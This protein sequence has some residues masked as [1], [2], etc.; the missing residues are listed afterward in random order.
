MKF[1]VIVAKIIVDMK[2]RYVLDDEALL[3][4]VVLGELGRPRRCWVLLVVEA[5]DIMVNNSHGQKLM[6]TYDREINIYEHR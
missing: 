1:V 4:L 2:R 3:L 5:D 6:G